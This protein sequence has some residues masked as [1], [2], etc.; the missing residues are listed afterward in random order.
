MD[1]LAK[2]ED[3][4]YM[5]WRQEY[6]EGVRDLHY[7]VAMHASGREAPREHSTLGSFYPS[8]T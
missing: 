4:R 2:T 1:E 7:W 8:G 3:Q 5:V 6:E